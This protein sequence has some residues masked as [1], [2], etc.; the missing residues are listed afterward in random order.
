MYEIYL[1]TN[2]INGKV[3]VGKTEFTAQQRWKKHISAV[4]WEHCQHRHLYC[5]IRKYGTYSFAVECIGTAK[6]ND[7]ASELE[8]FWIKFYDAKNREVGYNHTDGGEGTVG[9]K[10]NE[11]D[12]KAVADANRRRVWKP[13]SR[14]KAAANVV[15]RD[16]GVKRSSESVARMVAAQNRPEVLAKHVFRRGEK[17][18]SE[19][20]QNISKSLKGRKRSK[21]RLSGE[22]SLNPP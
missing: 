1:I 14:A 19:T 3:Y 21:Q 12:R 13:E 15:K 20:C 8:T 5:A 11:K 16:T 22:A 18:S 17:R 10:R 9:F 7:E 6:N 2:K 4:N